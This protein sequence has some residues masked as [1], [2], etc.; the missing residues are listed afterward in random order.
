MDF[1]EDW[2][3]THSEPYFY[4]AAYHCTTKKLS[5]LLM[6]MV[7]ASFLMLLSVKTK[8]EVVV[9]RTTKIVLSGNV[10]MNANRSS[11]QK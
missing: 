10:H 8:M 1:G 9:G 3:T 7:N 5:F 4:D 6:T 11:N 2:H